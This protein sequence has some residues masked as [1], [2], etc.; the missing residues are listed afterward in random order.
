[1]STRAGG[2]ALRPAP[3]LGLDGAC[4]EVLNPLF[5][6]GR[7]PIPAAGRAEGVARPLRSTSHPPPEPIECLEAACGGS[8]AP[9]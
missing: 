2:N 7:L 3:V 5:A 6:A 1:M 9:V 4:F 8:A